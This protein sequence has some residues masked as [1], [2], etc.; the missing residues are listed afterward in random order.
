[1]SQLLTHAPFFRLE[2]I[3]YHFFLIGLHFS[4]A[5]SFFGTSCIF[6]CPQN[7]M[8]TFIKRFDYDKVP[9]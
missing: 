4:Y 1:M 9:V 2:L 6:L 7:S 8:E 3:K 5:R